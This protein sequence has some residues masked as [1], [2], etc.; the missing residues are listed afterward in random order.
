MM[1]R[2]SLSSLVMNLTENFLNTMGVKEPV[3]F[4]IPIFIVG[5]LTHE[6]DLL[7]IVYGL[8]SII[9]T[10]VSVVTPQP[11]VGR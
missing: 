7:V 8:E 9:L 5:K 11:M 2:N 3:Y 6:Q 10:F 1:Y 4:R